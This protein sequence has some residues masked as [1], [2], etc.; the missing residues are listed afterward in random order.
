MQ[1]LKN[2]RRICWQPLHSEFTQQICAKAFDTFIVSRLKEIILYLIVLWR[3]RVRGIKPPHQTQSPSE[4]VSDLAWRTVC[5]RADEPKTGSQELRFQ[6]K[7]A[8]ILEW[9]PAGC[10]SLRKRIRQ[11]KATFSGSV[12]VLNRDSRTQTH[13]WRA[14]IS[15]F[16]WPLSVYHE[17][18]CKAV[19]GIRI[20]NVFFC[21]VFLYFVLSRW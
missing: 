12:C 9:P 15:Q 5:Q 19:A 11:K 3:P 4:C 16:F 7:P 21:F 6:W 20:Q 13:F 10:S 14:K 2:R 18:Q 1:W 17:L 8:D